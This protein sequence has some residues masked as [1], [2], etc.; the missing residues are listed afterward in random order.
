MEIHILSYK[1]TVE[2]WKDDIL[3]FAFEKYPKYT[4]NHF[5]FYSLLYKIEWSSNIWNISINKQEN[6]GAQLEY[7]GETQIFTTINY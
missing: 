4:E 3:C 5:K 1:K 7:L 6:Q 2:V